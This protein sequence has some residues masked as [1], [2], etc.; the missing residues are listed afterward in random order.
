MKTIL[1]HCL[2]SRKVTESENP[3]VEKTKNGR[4]ML[5]SKCAVCDSTKLKFIKEKEAKGLL[6][7]LTGIKVPILSHLSIVNLLFWKSTMNAIVNKLLLARDTFMPKMYLKQ[8]GY[9]YSACGPFTKNKEIV[10]LN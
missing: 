7:K 1:F 5:L 10:K 6:S 4:I 8:P 9:T 2:K 3:K